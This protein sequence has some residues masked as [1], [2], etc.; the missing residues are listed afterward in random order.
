MIYV[1]TNNA[2]PIQKVVATL[3]GITMLALV[4]TFSVVIIPV[5]VVVGLIGF[6][7]FYW[8]TRALRKAVAMSQVIRDNNVI[9]GEAVVIS[10]SAEGKPL[11]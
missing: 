10:T 5:L 1:Q 11:N 3:L 6:G 8:K 2:S 4:V 9:E 7:Y